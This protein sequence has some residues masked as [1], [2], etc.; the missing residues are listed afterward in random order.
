MNVKIP[1]E[2][3]G[4]IPRPCTL[5]AEIARLGDGTGRALEPLYK[6]ALR[7]TLRRS[8]AAGSPV[9]SDRKQ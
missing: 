5:I 9:N 4:S 1:T 8:E 2:P 7:D 3:V 6:E